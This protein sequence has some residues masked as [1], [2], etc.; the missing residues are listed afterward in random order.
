MHAHCTHRM[1]SFLFHALLLFFSLSFV[2]SSLLTRLIAL[3][4]LPPPSVF[5]QR[6]DLHFVFFFFSALIYKVTSARIQLFC[7]QLL[8]HIFFLS[9][10]T[11]WCE[12][13]VTLIFTIEISNVL[14]F[15]TL[16]FFTH[17]AIEVPFC[18]F[19]FF[20][21]IESLHRRGIVIVFIPFSFSCSIKNISKNFQKKRSKNRTHTSL[22]SL[23]NWVS[24]KKL[25]EM[26]MCVF[27]SEC[28][29]LCLCVTLWH[30]RAAQLMQY[31]N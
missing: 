11:Q 31:P 12:I 4:I 22:C 21:L 25:P 14:R 6:N 3:N 10:S 29:C 8:F 7:N 28:V 18:Q 27:S 1:N 5:W 19:F 15:Q 26:K 20:D 30:M 17:W 2:R 9:R 16:A 13:K 23:V 24:V